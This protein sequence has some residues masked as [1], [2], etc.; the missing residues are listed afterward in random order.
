MRSISFRGASAVLALAFAPLAAQ[1]QDRAGQ[2]REDIEFVRQEYLP[3]ERAFTPETLAEAN[4][5]LDQ[6]AARAGSMSDEEFF[7]GFAEVAA[8]A[9]NAHSTARAGE[10]YRAEYWLPI[11]PTWFDD[12]GLVILR[13][14]PPHQ[15]LAGGVITAIEG[16][17][18]EEAMQRFRRF[19]GGNDARRNILAPTLL[20][21]TD[22]LVGAGV[23]DSMQTTTIRVRLRDG[24]EVERELASVRG[25]E[26]GQAGWWPMRYWSPQPINGDATP[27]ATA[28]SADGLPLYLQNADAF[29]SAVALPELDAVYL[30]LK[31]NESDQEAR[32]FE[33]R[34]EAVLRTAR[35]TNIIVDLRFSTGGD[36]RTT[37]S[38]FQELPSRSPA[39]GRIFV[40]VGRYT[41]SAGMASAA[42][43]LNA[44]G[45]R[46]TL[47]GEDVG[48]RL[49][50][51]SEGETECAPN[52]G[53]CMRYTTG[54]FDMANGCTGQPRCHTENRRFN[55]VVGSLRPTLY[56]PT[57]WVDYLAG[58]DPAMDAIRA[59]LGR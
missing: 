25:R 32:Q 17:P 45:D 31:S 52:S 49:R 50:F 39:N 12:A 27:W 51:Y 59:A 13:A 5:L 56:A 8:T 16:R 38:F 54:L 15:D 3:R 42:I 46:A 58:R 53:F 26:R 36:M 7:L 57:T 30:E 23:S 10:R 40:I 35:A 29:N 18:T 14:L 48:D 28:I 6:L 37:A 21:V 34:A 1:A 20:S 41:F 19:Y 47:V 9:D 22:M 43:L 33:D 24:T 55:L 11:I 2:Q 4:R 44:A